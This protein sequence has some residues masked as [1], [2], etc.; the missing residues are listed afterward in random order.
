MVRESKQQAVI[1]RA[2]SD[3][4][5][6]ECQEREYEDDE[7]DAELERTL[8]GWLKRQSEMVPIIHFFLSFLFFFPFHAACLLSSL[9]KFL[10]LHFC[11]VNHIDQKLFCF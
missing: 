7:A 4:K 8:D 9:S 2:C 10:C 5:G 1:I 6:E 11:V 3:E